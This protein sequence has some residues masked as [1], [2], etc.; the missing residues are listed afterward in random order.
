MAI[1]PDLRLLRTSLT[2]AGLLDQFS[3]APSPARPRLVMRWAPDP[4]GRLA[5]CWATE[6]A[7]A[8][9]IAPD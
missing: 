1:L 2:S 9:S 6:N 4:D 7:G 8:I 3:C 5:A